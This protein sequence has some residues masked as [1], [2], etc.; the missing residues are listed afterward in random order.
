MDTWSDLRSLRAAREDPSSPARSGPESAD[1]VA[2]RGP[3]YDSGRV[4]L[5]DW[6]DELMDAL[7]IETEVDEGLVLDVAREAAHRVER[8]AAPISTYLLGYAAALAGG[9]TEKV[10]TLAGRA[11]ALADKWEGEEDLDAE[12]EE[13]LEIDES[14]ASSS[15]P[16]D[17]SLRRVTSLGPMRAVVATEPGGPEVLTLGD[18]PDPEPGPGEVVIDVAATAVNRADLLQRQ[19][20]YPP[21]PGASDILGLECSGT[22]VGR[23]RRTSSAGTSATRCARCSPAAGTPSRCSS[24][25][26][27]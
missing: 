11:L 17:R 27:R 8:P 4:N 18:L 23:R 12:L 14:E 5:H 22:V 13:G 6:I 9:D 15:T 16:S 21:P 3:A 1:R 10:E 19:G 7:D 20:F 25:P 26:G 24:R 2:S